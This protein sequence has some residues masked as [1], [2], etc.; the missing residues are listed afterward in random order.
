M[1]S[2]ASRPT[3]KPVAIRS[4]S[5]SGEPSILHVDMDAFF[6]SVEALE[7]PDLRNRPL[8]VGGSGARG[9]VAS[10]SYEARFFGVRSAMPSIR[11][12]RLCPQAIFVDGQYHLYERYSSQMHEVLT[13]FTPVVEGISIDEA[14]LDVSGARRLFGDAEQIAHAVRSRLK[15]EL[16]LCASV[17]VATTKH[18]AKLA[19]VAAKPRASRSG[20][21][22]GSGV[23]VVRHE[24]AFEFLHPMPVRA[25]WGVGPKTA[26]RLISVGIHTVGEL[27]RRSVDQLESILGGALASHLYNLAWNRDDRSVEP[28]QNAKSIG[29]EQTY[30]EDIYSYDELHLQWVRLADAVGTRLREARTAGRTVTCKF[31]YTTFRTITRSRTFPMATSNTAQL[32]RAADDITRTVDVSDG[33]RL[34]GLSVSNLESAEK[35]EQLEF[36]S[37][38]DTETSS[39]HDVLLDETV[40]LIRERYGSSAVVPALLTGVKSPGLLRRGDQQWGPNRKPPQKSS[41]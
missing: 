38:I 23:V 1:A 12:K 16:G 34:L 14:F 17:G 20:P 13:S 4:R 28:E 6:A 25:L 5:N 7:N 31:R 22:E 9:V 26:D 2:D 3:V 33:V 8:I 37:S 32:L 15:S 35:I 40:D 24:N 11:A 10:C 39:D 41:E 18:L 27:A 30:A 21:I 19:S 29:H 36:G